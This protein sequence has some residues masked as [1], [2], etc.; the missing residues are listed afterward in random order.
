MEVKDIIKNKRIEMGFT[1]KELA[2][3]VGVNE[4]TISRWESG[5]IASMKQTMIVKLCA[6]LNLTPTD[7]VPGITSP[8]KPVPNI[9]SPAQTTITVPLPYSPKALE[10]ARKFDVVD[11]RI[12]GIVESILNR[13]YDL[14]VES[15]T[16]DAGVSL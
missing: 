9:C 16:E 15:K 13:E 3:R 2:A 7:I 11:E 5:N 4:S 6:A 12:Q 10:I 8:S 14:T 1:M